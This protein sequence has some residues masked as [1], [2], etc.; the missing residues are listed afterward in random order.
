MFDSLQLF[1]NLNYY[2]ELVSGSTKKIFSHFFWLVGIISL[3]LGI[4]LAAQSAPKL[5]SLEQNLSSDVIKNFPSQLII[6]WDG[7]SLNIAPEETAPYE[8]NWPSSIA[9]KTLPS[10]LAVFDQNLR[11]PEE[12]IKQIGNKSSLFLINR[13][14]LWVLSQSSNSWSEPVPL[15]LILKPEYFPAQVVNQ[16]NLP[17]LVTQFHQ[18][19]KKVV[20]F[21]LILFPV[22]NVLAYWLSGLIFSLTEA[23]FIWIIGK[24]IKWPVSWVQIFKLNLLIVPVGL[25]LEIIANLLYPELEWSFFHI[26]YWIIFVLI[27]L[28]QTDLLYPKNKQLN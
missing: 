2:L 12:T 20:Q 22:T 7:T 3:I 24:I 14:N 10:L 6:N 21:G 1:F 13:T 11:S 15:N 5:Y 9:D 28:R 8:I 16:K 27:N 18:N 19:F 4:I 17:E 26:T 25:S 23:S